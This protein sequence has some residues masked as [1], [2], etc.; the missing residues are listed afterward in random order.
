[1]TGTWQLVRL[2]LRR[3][4]VLMPLW[5]VL[6]G[7]IPLY[8][9]SAI[10]QLYPTAAGLHSYA[11][12]SQSN[13]T[14][15]TLYTRVYDDSLGGL[16]FWRAN[17]TTLILGLISMFT[18]IRH[19]RT[20]E[21]AGRREL[22]GSAVVGR[23]AGLA[24]ALI[25]TIAAN[26]LIAVLV[27]LGL[28]ALEVPRTGAI[29]FGLTWAAAGAMFA[30]V[31]A[32]VA[33][34]TESAGAARGIGVIVAGAAFVLRAVGDVAGEG[35]NPMWL[36]WLSPL[37]WTSQVHPFGGEG[38]WIFGLAVAFVV[39]VSAAA[40]ALQSRRDVAAGLLPAGLG[41]AEASPALRSPLALA[42]RLHRANLLGWVAG[43]IV[44][45]AIF[46]GIA[47]TVQDM[48]ADNE[49]LREMFERL[50]G[51]AALSDIFIAGAFSL[52]GVIA[53][54][55]AVQAA[56]RMRTEEAALRSEPVLATPVSRLS[57][58]MSH[59]A[60]ALL[61]PAVAMVATGLTGGLVYGAS[62]GNVGHELPRVLAAAVI[63]LPAVWV[64]AGIAVAAFGFWPRLAPALGWTALGICAFLTLFGAAVRLS[65]AVL[66]ISPFTHI[67]RVPG[68]E[69]SALPLVLLLAIA[70]GLVAVGL[71]GFR[72]RD[73]PVT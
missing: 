32:L 54:G 28:S 63:P 43:F 15:I 41:P 47:K 52:A 22:V 34:L 26:L 55:Y 39:V 23:Q 27:V 20:E 37:G 13:S 61:G 40:F 46:G 33:Q 7:L 3:D 56:L 48:F 65:Q 57:W 59:L 67:P 73:V 11:V 21:E 1:M 9:G 49:Q 71:T 31:G 16:T 35:T 14:F 10:H 42:W 58:A 51:K 5:V 69:V 64:L 8:L 45:G 50:G 68:G 17:F 24:A 72:R 66:D 18:V 44:L 25:T 53:A 38:W 36:S 6:V 12:E 30:A 60:F 29:A 4:R 62:V 70:V 19:T 2:I